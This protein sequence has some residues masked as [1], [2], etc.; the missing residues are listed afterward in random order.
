[1]IKFYEE[2]KRTVSDIHKY[3]VVKKKPQK[4]KYLKEIYTYLIQWN[5]SI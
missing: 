4:V 2:K 5:L 1:M 3:G